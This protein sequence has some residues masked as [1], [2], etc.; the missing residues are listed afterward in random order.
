LIHKKTIKSCTS[1]G[2]LGTISP[3]CKSSVNSQFLNIK[4]EVDK[5]RK[6]AI[7]TGRKEEKLNVA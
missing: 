2:K 3:A 6:E 7:M 5:R 1:W 4:K